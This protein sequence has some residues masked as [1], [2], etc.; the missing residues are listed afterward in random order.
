MSTRDICETT[1]PESDLHN[2]FCKFCRGE[3][4]RPIEEMNDGPAPMD[5]DEAG[6]GILFEEGA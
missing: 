6:Q 1:V 2:G 4:D 5:A 3:A